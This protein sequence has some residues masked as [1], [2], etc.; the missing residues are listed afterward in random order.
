[1]VRPEAYR[2]GDRL[3]VV[4]RH[5]GLAANAACIEDLGVG[6]AVESDHGNLIGGKAVFFFKRAGDRSDRRNLVRELAAQLVGQHRAVR[7]AG[8]VDSFRIYRVVADQRFDQRADEPHV[9]EV[10]H[11]SAAAAIAGIPRVFSFRRAAGAFRINGDE[12]LFFRLIRHPGHVFHLLGIAV[13]A[14]QHDDERQFLVRHVVRRV[15]VVGALAVL[16]FEDFERRAAQRGRGT[17]EK[18]EKQH[19]RQDERGAGRVPFQKKPG[20][21]FLFR[22]DARR[23]FLRFVADG[24]L[25]RGFFGVHTLVR[26]LE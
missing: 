9:V 19:R 22:R 26:D 17:R 5:A 14:V 12:A 21:F 15:H 25:L 10:I 2:V 24:H 4:L 16:V 20:L 7:E 18:N 3:V 13:G 8:D 11:Q 1:M 6:G 23:G